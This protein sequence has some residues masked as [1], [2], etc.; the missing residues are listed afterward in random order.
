MRIPPGFSLIKEEGFFVIARE[1]WI[2]YLARRGLFRPSG[3][4]SELGPSRG[5]GGLLLVER[6]ALVI[7][8]NRH[9][10]ILAKVLGDLY[11]DR[12]RPHRELV[13]LWRLRNAGINT[14]EPVA[15]VTEKRGPFWRG[16][17]MTKYLPGAVDLLKFL[18]TAEDR[19]ERMAIARKAGELVRR[20]H[21]LGVFHADLQLRNFL[22]R[23]E[24][25]YIIDLDRSWQRPPLPPSSRFRN[26]WRLMRSAEKAAYFGL[27]KLS[28]RE[29]AAFWQGYSR[30]DHSLREELRKG[31][32]LLPY[33]RA[34]WRLGWLLEGASGVLE[35][36]P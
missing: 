3:V 14:L 17:L 10:G 29:L 34:F 26:L 4:L 32:R 7:R 12:E 20:V 35:E 11:L 23:E 36:V 30:G 13:L 28:P 21:D 5:T 22:V 25:V 18:A 33:R 15:S 8:P 6:E 19:R 9:G 31:L 24:E 1:D 27:L 16:Y 2:P